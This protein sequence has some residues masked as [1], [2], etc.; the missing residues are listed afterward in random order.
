MLTTRQ[1][2]AEIA[3]TILNRQ[4]HGH[5]PIKVSTGCITSMMHTGILRHD[6]NRPYKEDL[7]AIFEATKVISRYD[8]P[9][10]RV[11]LGPLS[12]S[13]PT[14]PLLSTGEARKYAGLDISNPHNLTPEEFEATYKGIW[15]LGEENLREAALQKAFLLPAVKGFIHGSLI[16]IVTGYD[17]DLTT[18]RRWIHSRPLTQAER[19]SLLPTGSGYKHLWL[20]IGKGPIAEVK[21]TD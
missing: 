17:L 13:G 2:A 11:S 1:E 10:V 4:A 7:I 9:F 5:E 21:T 16:E 15:P 14:D 8:L 3:S 20:N 12:E 6:N 18:G 19:E